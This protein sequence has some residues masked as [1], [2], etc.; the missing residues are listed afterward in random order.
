MAPHISRGLE[1]GPTP[2]TGWGVVQVYG[3][4]GFQGNQQYGRVRGPHFQAKYRA[5]PWGLAAA[6]EW[7]LSVD[8][9][10]N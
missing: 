7:L 1:R 5:I 4:P 6:S 8:N 2:Y 9:Q 3:A 10:T